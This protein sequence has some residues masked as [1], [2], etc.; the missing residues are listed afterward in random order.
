MNHS[1]SPTG[2]FEDRLLAELRAR[3][4]ERAA[5][6]PMLTPR[7]V[8]SGDGDRPP[9]RG[10]RRAP[11]FALTGAAAVAIA[12]AG[13]IVSAGGD[14]TEAA[15]AVQPRADGDVSVEI[16][17]LSDAAGLEQALRQAGVPADVTYLPAGESCR[18]P[19]FV[20]ARGE[21]GGK[22]TSAMRQGDGGATTFTISRDAVGPGQTLVLTASSAP[23]GGTALQM[24]VADGE[25][26]PCVTVA[27]TPG[28]DAIPAPPPGADVQGSGGLR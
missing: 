11:R 7:T 23:G 13:L 5:E 4:A 15:Y 26:K 16:K 9:S 8:A 22:V 27:A 24:G 1:T 2:S 28:N 3:V 25:V 18:E 19:R 6:N 10:P 17:A 14:G 21:P 12:A 20:P